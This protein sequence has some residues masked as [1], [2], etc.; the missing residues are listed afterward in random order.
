MIPLSQLL[1]DKTFDKY[2][3]TT[4]HLYPIQ[5]DGRLVWRVWI[6]PTQKSPWRKKD[7]AR[8]SNAVELVDARL[9]DV[10][11][12]AVQCRGRSYQPPVK[13]VQIVRDGV[14]QFDEAGHRLVRSTVWKTPSALV[15]SYGPHDWCYYCRRPTV[16]AYI[17]NHHAF[18]G[19]TLGA[20]ATNDVR[21]CTLCGISH[22]IDR[23]P[24]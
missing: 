20:F 8:Y 15:Q 5:C 21:R 4:P 7:V 10:Y 12:A 6:K 24:L 17:S 23:R 2:F 14:P 18:R 1:E 11:D 9:E 13:R 22:D 3:H 19:T 16:F